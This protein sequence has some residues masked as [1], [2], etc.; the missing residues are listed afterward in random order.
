MREPIAWLG[1]PEADIVGRGPERAIVRRFIAGLPDG[2][3]ELLIRG[4]AGIGKTTLWRSTLRECERD[5]PVIL[6]ARPAEEELPL[7]LAG[8]VDLFEHADLDTSALLAEPNPFAR[9]RSVLAALRALAARAPVLI[10]IDDLQWLDA[11]S[12]RALRF[13]LRRLQHE[14]V[15]V[16]ATVRA[17]QGTSDPLALADALPPERVQVLDLGPL[18]LDAL[19][20]VLARA[21]EDHSRAALHRIHTV[22]GGNPLHAI[23]LARGLAGADARLPTSLPVAIARRLDGVD[24]HLAALLR[25][26]A[27]LGPASAAELRDGAGQEAASQ[28]AAA[29]REHLLVIGDDGRVR[30]AH[31]LFGTVV[32]GAMAP[33][34][35]R[36]VHARLARSAADPDARARH[37]ALATEGPDEAAALQLEEAAER[38]RRRG[39]LDLAGEFVGHSRRLTAPGDEAATLRRG[40]A[41]IEDLTVAGDS[42]RALALADELLAE[43][44]PGPARAEILLLR[45]CVE[46]DHLDV[47]EALLQQALEDSAP[48]PRLHA[49]VLDQFGWTLSLFRGDLATGLERTR[50]AI[51]IAEREGDDTRL[52]AFTASHAYLEGLAGRPSGA[53]CAE[54]I[55][56]APAEVPSLWTAPATMV[57]ELLLWAGDLDGARERFAADWEASRRTG[58]ELQQPYGR[59]DLALVACAAGS[60]EAAEMHV[61]DGMQA[62]RDME[63]AWAA[64]LLLYPLSLVLA[65]RGRVDEARA[66]ADRRIDEARARGERP[67]I[68]RGLGVLGLLA[69]SDGEPALAAHHLRDA[70]ALLEAMGY[71]NPGAYPV[72]P[73]AVEALAAAGEADGAAA[74]LRRLAI[75][76]ER[77]G[78]AWAAAATGRAGGALRLATGDPEAAADELGAAAAGFERLG[79]RPDAARAAFLRGR[80]LLRAGQRVAAADVLADARRRF[81][82]MGAPLWAGRA[83]VEL[84]RA[85]PGRASGALTPAERRIAELVAEGKRNREIGQALLMSVGTVEGHLTRT[86]RK[87]GIRSRSELARRVADGSLAQDVG[88]TP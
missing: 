19:R 75:E 53:V 52:T 39:A 58:T 57:G 40:A 71:A 85:S 51:R 26:A 76:A 21:V 12:A 32:Y 45:G 43:L 77:S 78:G 24:P 44:P 30:F 86:Y 64:R 69:L 84:D 31:P 74:L 81:E 67:G 4:E 48:V 18:G 80:A 13:A 59:F 87:L 63:D 62:A 66:A 73:D 47:S 42:S 61:R 7:G 34:E 22:S 25:T 37:L 54:A 17:G 72:L 33:S 16:F 68:V 41:E 2:P 8:L 6:R 82:A 70:A 27:A 14:P 29:E 50:E 83:A 55:G 36:A 35:R 5:G 38:A 20:R 56:L 23:E 65:W 10:A 15:G 49:R 3:C 9:A 46:D 1:H 60:F 11:M 79:C 28:L 88:E